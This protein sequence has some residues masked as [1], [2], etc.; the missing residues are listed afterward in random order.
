MEAKRSSGDRFLVAVVFR[1]ALFQHQTELLPEFLVAFGVVF[2]QL[3]QHLQHA[4]GQ[5]AAQVLRHAAVLQNLARHVQ[6]QIVGID[7]TTHEAQVVRHELLGVVHDE[8]ALH[9]QFQAVLVI[10][11]PHVPRRLRRD[12]QQAGVLLLAFHP[13]V[14]P[15]Q[16]IGEIV[17]D[18]LVELFVL[19]IGHVSL[20]AGPQGL[21]LVDLFP[22]DSIVFF[23]LLSISTGKAM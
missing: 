13:V 12:I 14:A 17:G 19:F 7:Q 18:V 23:V 21:C 4:L 16:R 1:R 2:G 6:R 20:A 10:A 3:I 9:V 22:G 11:V 5:R 15:A 8:H